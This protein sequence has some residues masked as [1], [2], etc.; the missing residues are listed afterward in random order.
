M[1]STG[2]TLAVYRFQETANMENVKITDLTVTDD[3]TSS[4]TTT[5]PA[6]N[7]VTLWNGSTDLGTAGS[8]SS[9]VGSQIGTTYTAGTS[10]AGTITVGGSFSATTTTTTASGYV[11]SNNF[12]A[13][14]NSS[15][16]ASSTAGKLADAIN[17]RLRLHCC[18]RRPP[19]HGHCQCKRNG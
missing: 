5:L 18:G 6:F 10:A 1:G 19:G 3:A 14:E 11:G 2:N 8:A 15:D 4:A 13:V 17:R 9:T 7:N 12:T 16:T